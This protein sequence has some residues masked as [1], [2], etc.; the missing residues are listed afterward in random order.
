MATYTADQLKGMGVAGENIS[1]PITFTFTNPG[2]SSYFTLETNRNNNGIYTESTPQCASGSW[3]AGSNLGLVYSPVITSCVVQPGTSSITFTPATS[4]LGINYKF[5]GTGIFN[6]STS[7]GVSS[8]LF[9]ARNKLSYPGSGSLWTNLSGSSNATLFNG[10]TYNSTDG[11]GSLRFDGIND[12]ARIPYD[13]SFNLSSGNYSIN[14]WTKSGGELGGGLIAKIGTSNTDWD[15]FTQNIYEIS[16]FNLEFPGD[17]PIWE[18]SSPLT[19]GVWKL[20]SITSTSYTA[21]IYINGVQNDI[22]RPFVPGNTVVGINYVYLMTDVGI[23]GYT[24]GSLGSVE[25]SLTPSSGSQI[26]TYF[27]NTKARF[28]Y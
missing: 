26:L 23:S 21:S 13:D 3:T 18:L 12:F 10:V 19:P 27:N 28:G 25:T 16:A 22:P 5:R 17:V 9:D 20:I 7:T 2:N 8:N 4:V 6:I 14:M 1:S 15:F 11:S 24:S